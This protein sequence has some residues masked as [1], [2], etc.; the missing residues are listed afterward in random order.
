MLRRGIRLGDV[1]VER[2]GGLSLLTTLLV[3]LAGLVCMA[4]LTGL[5]GGLVGVVGLTAVLRGELLTLELAGLTAEGIGGTLVRVLL[6]GEV[7]TREVL[8]GKLLVRGSL[9]SKLLVG[10][11]LRSRD[12]GGGRGACLGGLRGLLGRG[13]EL[14]QR[15]VLD[16]VG[17]GSL[18]GCGLLNRLGGLGNGLC[19]NIC[20]DG[21]HGNRRGGG[22]HLGNNLLDHNLLGYDGFCGGL[23]DRCRCLGNRLSNGFCGGLFDRCRCLGNRLSNGLRGGLLNGLCGSL[24]GGSLCGGG[25]AGGVQHLLRQG[26][27]LKRNRGQVAHG[28][29]LC[30]G[31]LGLSRLCAGLLG[32]DGLGRDGLRG[33]LFDR[34]RSLCG[35]LGR[36]NSRLR[37]GFCVCLGGGLGGAQRLGGL[38]RNERLQ[39]SVIGIDG[40]G[41]GLFDPQLPAIGNGTPGRVGAP[42]GGRGPACGRGG[43]IGRRVED[44]CHKKAAF[45]VLKTPRKSGHQRLCI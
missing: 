44:E 37:N 40:L 10:E 6:A 24:C 2:C 3:C 29:R 15:G 20:G 14:N 21:G 45:L 11:G 12:V 43:P 4:C 16:G 9:R 32:R 36:L 38:F 27:L 25:F 18:G 33:S 1:G 5:A 7:L 31:L 28:L 23:F 39:G 8:T 35:N 17:Q 26:G 30:L 19:G 34:D 42:G 22:G 13:V 41:V